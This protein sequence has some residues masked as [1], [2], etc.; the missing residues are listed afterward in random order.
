M[1]VPIQQLEA[2]LLATNRVVR[3]LGEQLTWTRQ[4]VCEL[5]MREKLREAGRAPRYPVEFRSQFG[6]DSYLWNLFGGQIDG[7]FIEVGAFDGYSFSVTYALECAGWNGLLIEALPERYDECR[8]RRTHSRVVHSALARRGAPPT[9]GFMIVQD[10]FGGMLSYLDKPG[11][12]QRQIQQEQYTQR[13]VSVPAATLDS[14]LAEHQGPIDVLVLDV[15]GGELD[16]LDGLDVKRFRPRVMLVEDNSYGRDQ[17]LTA[18]FAA[19]PYVHAGW[20]E[21]NRVYIHKD[22]A[23]LLAR[24]KAIK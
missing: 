2:E 13:R 23:A 14:L 9:V 17:T 7:F 4:R 12:H 19:Q 1:T 8:K 16:A 10:A 3:R 20:V 18:H 24:A 5:E 11:E 22:E 15:E 6:E 21:V